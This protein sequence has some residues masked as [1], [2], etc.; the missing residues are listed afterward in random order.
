[1]PLEVDRDANPIVRA[2]AKLVVGWAAL[3]ESWADR[4]R[5]NIGWWVLWELSWPLLLLSSF[6]H[7]V[8]SLATAIVLYPI[9]NLW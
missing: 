7:T 1:M 6:L 3:N 4:A 2:N 5:S 8:Y 9:D